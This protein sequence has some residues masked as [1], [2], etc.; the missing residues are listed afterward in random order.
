MHRKALL[1]TRMHRLMLAACTLF[2]LT[3]FADTLLSMREAMQRAT[4][5][6]PYL[7]KHD[8]QMLAV[9]ELRY[10]D[11]ESPAA[12]PFR[13]A[14]ERLRSKQEL[15]VQDILALGDSYVTSDER[16]RRRMERVRM[17]NHDA[18]AQVMERE[19]GREAALAWLRIYQTEHALVLQNEMQRAMENEVASANIGYRAGMLMQADVWK[20][21]DMLAASKSRLIELQNEAMAARADL[22]RWLG[23][24]PFAL[25]NKLDI[26]EAPTLTALEEGLT[27]LPQQTG[28]WL[29][30]SIA[31]DELKKVE[32]M[33][34]SFTGPDDSPQQKV[35]MA[36]RALRD[37]IHHHA[38]D[39]LRELQ[40]EARKAFAEWNAAT[41]KRDLQEQSVLPNAARRLQAT[42]K[43]YG[44]GKT[45]F[46]EVLEARRNEIEA[47]MQHL[48]LTVEAAKARIHLEMYE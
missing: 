6:Q 39:N 16:M 32:Q 9:T 40:A 19:V 31:A 33:E 27:R 46:A 5:N 43:A 37:S 36:M 18:E 21:E 35:L 30:K 1:R 45:E 41:N 28:Y 2:P 42:V 8:M 38:L 17:V 25:D 23:D 4:S 11:V 47:R 34:K 3:C 26:K 10:I 24:K 13:A 44:V 12:A 29:A 15:L 20:A 7:Q 22:Q 14:I 48:H